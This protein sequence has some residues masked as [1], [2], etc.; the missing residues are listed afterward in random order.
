VPR[1]SRISLSDGVREKESPVAGDVYYQPP[2]V[3]APRCKL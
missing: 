3:L 1:N 2:G